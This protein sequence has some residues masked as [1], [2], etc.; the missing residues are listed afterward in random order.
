ME[1]DDVRRAEAD[2]F[3]PVVKCHPVALVE[4]RGSRVR[5]LD[6]RWLIDLMAGWGVTCIGHSHPALVAAISDQ[7]GRLMQTTNIF[8]TLPQTELVVA[9]AECAPPGIA[10]SFFTSSGTEAVEGALK[11]A[12]RATGRSVFVSTSGA[13][14]GR[15]LG[16]LHVIGTEKH[17]APYAPLL[18]ESVRIPF[19]DVAAAE[20]AI[21]ERTAA[22]IVEP[23]QG[24]GGVNVP[25]DGYLRSLRERC[26]AVGALLICDE[27]QTGIGRTG[28]LFACEHEGVTPDILTLGKGLGGGFPVAAFLCTEEVAATVQPG[29]H[30]TTYGGNP[31]ACAA[32]LAVLRVVE[33]EK[34][35]ARAADLGDRLAERLGAFVASRPDRALSVRGRGLLQALILADADRAAALPARALE[36]GVVVN[37]TAGNVVRFF[38]ALNI[39]EEELWEG[40][41]AVLA[42]VAD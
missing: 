15:T 8:Y 22:V 23:V 1:M 12:H 35:V 14:H 34:L 39:P 40:V 18:H 29:D 17:R 9:L 33:E 11:L 13:F 10:R 28:K 24:E 2:H 5:D 6:G 36:R 21:D 3:L 38:P 16:A 25:G 41:D 31:L 20:R 32:A 30:G 42:L 27:V 7:A 19:D 4:G 37:V 26:H